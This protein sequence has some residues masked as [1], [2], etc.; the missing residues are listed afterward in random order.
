MD[1]VD[2]T[3]IGAGVVGLAIAARIADEK[4]N[5]IVLDKNHTFGQE[6]SSRNSEVIH[7]GIYYPPGSLKSRLCV[8]GNKKL[9]EI[10]RKHNITHKRIGKLIVAAD[11]SEVKELEAFYQRGVQNGNTALEMV[12]SKELKSVEPHIR[13]VAAI[14]SPDTGIID[15]HSLMENFISQ[16]KSKGVQFVYQAKVTGVEKC[17]E[18]LQVNI[19]DVSGD[20]SFIT[21]VLINSAG[22]HADKVAEMTGIDIDNAGY[23]IHFCKGEY[24]SV[25]RGKNKLV[26]RLIYPV[27]SADLTG[28]GIHITLDL[29]GRMRLGPSAYY[30]DSLDYSMD[31]CYKS[32]FYQSAK[33]YLPELEVDDIQPDMAGIRPK[34]QGPG[35][36]FRDFII[37]EESEKGLPGLINL[38]GIESPGLTCSPA[39]AEY[40]ANFCC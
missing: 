39:I 35:D 31:L 10:C 25:G 16:A 26:Q 21:G 15:S 22:L 28:L 2:I 8:E 3:I 33:A 11:E 9:Y 36:K 34:L 4:K 30:L 6:T 17:N 27:P 40:V 24:Y 32:E 19:E 18:G 1:K 23:R 20:Y 38:I 7:S 29:G 14:R 5:I 12:S 37:Q 13:A